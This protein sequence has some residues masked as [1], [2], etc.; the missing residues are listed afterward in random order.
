MTTRFSCLA[1]IDLSFTAD[2]KLS[3]ALYD[4]I[5]DRRGKR[6]MSVPRI[7]WSFVGSL[8]W[9][10]GYQPCLSIF[11]PFPLYTPASTVDIIST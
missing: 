6:E 5:G 10:N 9:I 2:N 8:W 4:Q 3:R 11:S 1:S 7:P